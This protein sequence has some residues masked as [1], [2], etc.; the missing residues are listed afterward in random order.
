[1]D[2]VLT[3]NTRYQRNFG[4]EKVIIE[5]WK[6]YTRTVYAN[7]TYGLETG[8]QSPTAKFLQPFFI[9]FISSPYSHGRF[10]SMY[11]NL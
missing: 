8:A 7:G 11:S 2:Y 1:M 3:F 10:S 6:P 4:V 5:Q 9:K